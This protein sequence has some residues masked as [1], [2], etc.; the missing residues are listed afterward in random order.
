MFRDADN[1]NQPIGNGDVSNVTNMT[2]M[3]F[4]NNAVNQDLSS[5]NLSNC[6]ECDRFGVTSLWTLLKPNLTNWTLN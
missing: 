5:W 1:F 6:L 3:F 4:L 2:E